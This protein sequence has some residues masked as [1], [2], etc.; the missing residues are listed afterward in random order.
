[1][2]PSTPI[3]KSSY[4]LLLLIPIAVVVFDFFSL[5]NVG[6]MYMDW[7]D[8]AYAYLYNSTNLAS[9]VM[10]V[11]HIDHPGTTAQVVG[12]IFVRAIYTFSGTKDSVAEDMIADPEKYLMTIA[13]ILACLMG[14]FLIWFGFAITRLSKS[15]ALGLFFQSALPLTFIALMFSLEIKP[16]PLIIFGT[17]T[18]IYHSYRY[19]FDTENPNRKDWKFVFGFGALGGFLIITKITTT[20]V[21][22]L[23]FLLLSGW[24]NKFI[25]VLSTIGFA[26]VFFIPALS[27]LDY[28][29][30]WINR[31]Y[32]HSGIYGGGSEKVIDPTMYVENLTLIFK[33]NF[34]TCFL[35]GITLI[36][37]IRLFVLRKVNFNEWKTNAALRWLI[38]LFLVIC[39]GMLLVAKHFGFHYLIPYYLL[40]FPAAWLGIRS[41][42]VNE[43]KIKTFLQNQ[44]VAV[45]I[46][47]LL[48]AYNGYDDISHYNWHDNLR[49]PKYQTAAIMAQYPDIPR[50]YASF[51]F[52]FSEPAPALHFGWCYSGENRHSYTP[53]L[54]KYYPNTLF[55]KIDS[56]QYRDW[57]KDLTPYE[58]ASRYKKLLL[59]FYLASPEFVAQT[60]SALEQLNSRTKS[61]SVNKIYADVR[62]GEELYLVDILDKID[63]SGVQ[64]IPHFCDAEKIE[65][66]FFI[67]NDNMVRFSGGEAVS[68]D[69]AHS[70]KQSIKL[71]K[72]FDFGLATKI[73]AIKGKEYEISVWR[74]STNGKGVLAATASKYE[75]L[76]ITTNFPEQTDPGGW[77]LLR[78]HFAVPADYPEEFISVYAYSEQSDVPVYFDDFTLTSF[79]IPAK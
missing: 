12:A 78:L 72:D 1:M 59:S 61:I 42:I 2:L 34:L 43:S 57:E 70:G 32:S 14:V 7:P 19:V 48:T 8:P 38:S 77:Q 76:G 20:P 35:F 75:I 13:H 10:E 54:K 31:I 63:T 49:N 55:Y 5:K 37:I 21:L 28:L 58:V 30:N 68:T 41:F 11:G 56:K 64:P 9:G 39:A 52:R 73:P 33:T 27:K 6:A 47:L 71:S 29:I 3:K 62:T 53:Y 65:N 69:F 25:Y 44:Y 67:S 60:M 40:M 50:L 26:F 74:K 51:E 24:K 17:L 16:E 66:N 15:L 23:P 36:A 22:V 45:S 46:V 4:L 18:L 79:D